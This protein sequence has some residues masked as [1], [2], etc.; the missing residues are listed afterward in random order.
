MVSITSLTVADIGNIKYRLQ[1]GEFQHL[2]AADFEVNQGRINEIHKG[3]RFG[4]IPAKFHKT[5]P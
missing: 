4:F 1:A 2:I 3:S 5:T